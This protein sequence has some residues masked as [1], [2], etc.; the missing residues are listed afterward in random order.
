MLLAGHDS[1]EEKGFT[2]AFLVLQ[3]CSLENEHFNMGMPLTI[4]LS[5]LM[6]AINFAEF[7]VLSWMYSKAISCMNIYASGTLRTA[8]IGQIQKNIS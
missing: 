4:Q 6:L 7:A 1:R 2:L 8:K 5:V 3:V